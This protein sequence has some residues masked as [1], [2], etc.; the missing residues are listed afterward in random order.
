M[1]SIERGQLPP[2]RTILPLPPTEGGDKHRVRSV[3]TMRYTALLG[4]YGMAGTRN[5]RGLS[6]EHGSVH[7]SRVRGA[8]A[9]RK[10]TG[11]TQKSRRACRKC[12]QALVI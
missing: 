4:H 7:S 5:N 6:H 10:Y 8:F 1:R 11:I 12:T 9:R 2:R 3:Y